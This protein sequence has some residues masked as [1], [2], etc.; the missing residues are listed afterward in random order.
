L[1]GLDLEVGT[2]GCFGLLGPNGSGKS[3]LFRI[4]STLTKPTAGTATVCGADVVEHP[5]RVREKIGVVFQ[6]PS[7][8]GKLRV[9]ENL[10]YAGLMYG[11]QGSE[12]QTRI[13]SAV[14]ALELKDRLRDPVETLSGGLKRRAEIAKSLLSNPSLLLLDEPST[15]LDPNAR[16]DM[17]RHLESVREEHGTT[18]LF[19][20]HLMDEAER[21]GQIAI[22]HE[23]KKV[24]EGEP[25]D[26]RAS[27]S[28]QIVTVQT[29]DHEKVV[30][31]LTDRLAS[32]PV[33][34]GGDVRFEAD[35]AYGLAAEIAKSSNARISSITVGVPTLEDVFVARTGR[36]FQEEDEEAA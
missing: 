27:I 29:P 31:E 2:G 18:L 36:A 30:A 3:T 33:V 15:G 35:D 16:S 14:E 11:I 5:M 34:V 17:W 26:L 28:G 7:L 20:T 13:E 24:A 22:L 9:G 8:D 21:A 32:A 23:G 25:T 12:L 6:A 19:T 4:L 10:Q 1:D